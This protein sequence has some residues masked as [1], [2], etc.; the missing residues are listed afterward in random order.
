LNNVHQTREESID[1][2]MELTFE[3]PKC[4]TT[5][6]VADVASAPALTCRSCGW[7][8]EIDP[9]TIAGGKLSSCV[10]CATDDLYIQKDFPHVLG[11][12]IVV[13]GFVVSSVFWA[14]YM[15]IAALLVLLST[16]ALDLVLYYVVPD[17]TICYRCLGQHR[18]PGTSPPGRFEPFDLAI[19]ERYRQERLRAEQLRERQQSTEVLP[20]S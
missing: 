11:V 10:V 18:G 1:R 15:P 4:G 12:T 20:P 2:P 9:R 8:R 6:E 7:T 3:C 13:A 19:G 14:Y 16:A 5:G 17:V